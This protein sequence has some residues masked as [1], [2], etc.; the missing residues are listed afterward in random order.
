MEKA[1]FAGGCFWCMEPAFRLK[2]GVTDVVVGYVG[3]T[4]TAAVVYDSE[5]TSFEE[6]L[7]VFWKGIDPTDD[8][9]QFHDRGETYHTKIFYQTDAEKTAAEKSKK[10][11][12]DSGKFD[13]PIAVRIEPFTNFKPAPEYHQNF[14]EKNPEHYERY[15]TASG[16]KGYIK[17]HWGGGDK[18]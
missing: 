10:D 3:P 18:K 14:A 11:L 15:A 4:E 17:E 13:K 9:G 1:Y 5:K 8:D 7:E 12:D 16:R 6:L 2:Q